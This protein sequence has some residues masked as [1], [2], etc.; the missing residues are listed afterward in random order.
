MHDLKLYQG[1]HFQDHERDR[2]NFV[3]SSDIP[4]KAKLIAVRCVREDWLGGE[5]V[6]LNDTSFVIN[7]ELNT[8]LSRNRDLRPSSFV[9]E[10]SIFLAKVTQTKKPEPQKRHHPIISID[11]NVHRTT[12][13]FDPNEVFIANL[14]LTITKL[15]IQRWCPLIIEFDNDANYKLLSSSDQSL[16]DQL[17]AYASN[18]ISHELEKRIRGPGPGKSILKRDYDEKY[19]LDSNE[20]CSLTSED[21][22]NC[23]QEKSSNRVW[24]EDDFSDYLDSDASFV[25]DVSPPGEVMRLATK[26]LSRPITEQQTKSFIT[27]MCNLRHNDKENYMETNDIK[28]EHVDQN[29]GI[30]EEESTKVGTILKS[31]NYD[32]FFEV[33]E[34]KEVD[35]LDSLDTTTIFEEDT[36]FE[37]LQSVNLVIHETHLRKNASTLSLKDFMEDN[38]AIEY[39]GPIV[40]DDSKEKDDYGYIAKDEDFAR[41]RD[42]SKSEVEDVHDKGLKSKQNAS[43]LQDGFIPKEKNQLQLE[44]STSSLERNVIAKLIDP[45]PRT[46]T[47]ADESENRNGSE[48]NSIPGRIEGLDN[49]PIPPMQLNNCE[50][51]MGDDEPFIPSPGKRMYYN[52]SP[53]KPD[54]APS[55]SSSSRVAGSIALFSVEHQNGMDFAF[56]S[57]NVPSFIKE[58]KKFRFIK[59]GKVQTYVHL[60]EEQGQQQPKLA[61]TSRTNS[62]VNS[63]AGSPK[64]SVTV[65]DE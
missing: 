36:P 43:Q 11:G 30:S 12:F 45:E 20:S 32:D 60:F 22:L 29:N 48:D 65:I 35:V 62:R 24:F 18:R 50:S 57:S 1:I 25:L 26:N 49:V 34:D 63:R 8:L 39:N 2:P 54:L 52:N 53:T 59:V 51:S 58:D 10:S 6:I 3:F 61:D 13:A 4:Q 9:K 40:N 64:V 44:N 56:K 41:N 15:K 16:V 27:D 42:S 33:P 47:L 5:E 46:P 14:T 31:V 21:T 23:S 19:Y 38:E 37:S 28:N 7:V 17:Q 55:S